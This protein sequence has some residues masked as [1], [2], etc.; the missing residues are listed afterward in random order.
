MTLILITGGQHLLAEKGNFRHMASYI[1]VATYY[2]KQRKI[3]KSHV[4]EVDFHVLPPGCLVALYESLALTEVVDHTHVKHFPSGVVD[5]V[6]ELASK[7]VHSH[8]AEY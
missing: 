6:V 7:E 3:A 5:A 8:D 2:L 4:V 1:K